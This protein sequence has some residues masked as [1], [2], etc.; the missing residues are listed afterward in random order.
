MLSQGLHCNFVR[1]P[2][3]GTVLLS[4]PRARL[5][6]EPVERERLPSRT[7]VISDV[8]YEPRPSRDEAQRDRKRSLVSPL[9]CSGSE[10]QR[11]RGA[12][13]RRCQSDFGC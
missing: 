11:V 3:Q 7:S 8:D 4:P 1:P 9:Q 5:P 12:F 6:G 10:L 13:R 2:L